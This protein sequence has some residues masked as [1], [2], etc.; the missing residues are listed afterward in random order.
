MVCTIHI[1]VDWR[2]LLIRFLLILHLDILNFVKAKAFRCACVRYVYVKNTLEDLMIWTV[3]GEILCWPYEYM[4]SHILLFPFTICIG[5]YLILH[6]L[7]GKMLLF[8]FHP[9]SAAISFHLCYSHDTANSTAVNRSIAFS[10]NTRA[11]RAASNTR[12]WS[13]ALCEKWL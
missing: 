8:S 5:E 6:S 12:L 3:H 10:F 2:V 7:G 9:Y 1:P 11:Q 13:G 4:R